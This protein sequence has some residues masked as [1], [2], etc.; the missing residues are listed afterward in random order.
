M[1]FEGRLKETADLMERIRVRL[2]DETGADHGYVELLF[3][4]PSPPH[5]INSAGI[6]FSAIPLPQILCGIQKLAA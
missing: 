4:H 2:G 6:Y 3:G 1:K 5:E